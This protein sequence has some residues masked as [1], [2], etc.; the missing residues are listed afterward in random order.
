[1]MPAHACTRA[2]L[3]TVHL[4]LGDFTA[5]E[6]RGDR[7]DALTVG[8]DPV[9]SRRIGRRRAGQAT[10]DAPILLT[11][12]PLLESSAR[13]MR[14]DPDGGGWR[15]R[16]FLGACGG[17]QGGDEQR[18][19]EER[20]CAS[21]ADTSC[22]GLRGERRGSRSRGSRSGVRCPS[23]PGFESRRRVSPCMSHARARTLI[24]GVDAQA[25]PLR[26]EARRRGG[27]RRVSRRDR[28]DVRRRIA[29][30]PGSGVERRSVERRRAERRYAGVVGGCGRSGQ[31]L[32]DGERLLVQSRLRVDPGREVDASRWNARAG[33]DRSAARSPTGRTIAR[34]ACP[35]TG[36]SSATPARAR[37]AGRCRRTRARTAATEESG[38][39]PCGKRGLFFRSGR[40][41][42]LVRSTESLL[43]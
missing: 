4:Q 2:A 21:A 43:S 10:E 38:E 42:A 15:R 19:G 6:R 27:N 16:T 39:S 35:P 14:A 11:G 26:P 41:V 17:G 36:S 12:A 25:S 30:G 29:G 24:E 31:G 23:S 18:E 22:S 13:S 40:G 34:A 8:E 20:A 33:R 3:R 32:P 28:P 7:R 5:L 37:R 1:M 9:L